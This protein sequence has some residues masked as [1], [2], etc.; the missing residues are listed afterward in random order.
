M[1][2]RPASAIDPPSPFF[3][4]KVESREIRLA[5]RPKGIPTAANFTLARVELE[6]PTMRKRT[7]QERTLNMLRWLL[8]ATILVFIGARLYPHLAS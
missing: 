2:Q 8:T 5:S 4:S 6:P 1:N 7:A 3:M